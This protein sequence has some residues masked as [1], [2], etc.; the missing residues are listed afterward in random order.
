MLKS[1]A[2]AAGRTNAFQVSISLLQNIEAAAAVVMLLLLVL[3]HY[4]LL[5]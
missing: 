3:R 2:V 1:E 5:D 4:R